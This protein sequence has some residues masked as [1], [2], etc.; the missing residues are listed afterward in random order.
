MGIPEEKKEGT[1]IYYS[2]SAYCED[3]LGRIALGFSLDSQDNG[4]NKRIDLC[5]EDRLRVAMK[6]A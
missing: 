2:Y 5:L 4:K 6:E 1:E 3:V